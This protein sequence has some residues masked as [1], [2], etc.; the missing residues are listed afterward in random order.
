MMRLA[1]ACLIQC[2][3]QSAQISGRAEHA[4]VAGE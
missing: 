1:V 2:L 3:I 4:Y